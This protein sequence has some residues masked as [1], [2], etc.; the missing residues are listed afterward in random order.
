MKIIGLTKEQAKKNQLRYGFNELLKTRKNSPIKIFFSQFADFL[1]ITLICAML[2]SAFMGEYSDAITVLII[3]ATNGVLGFVQE[4]KTEKSLEALSKLSAPV[5]VVVRDGEEITIPSREVTV[6]DVVVLEAGD[7][8]C[9]DCTVIESTS[10]GVDESMLTGESV[11]IEKDAIKNTAIYMG[12]TVISGRCKARAEAIGMSTKMGSIAHLLENT[13]SGETPLKKHL[14]K[15]GRELV[16]ICL[17][18]CAL[19]FVAG[20]FHG[21]SVYNMFLSS[22]SLA[23]AAIPEG[24]PAVVTVSLS[25]GVSRMLKRNALIRKLPAVE[26]LGCTNVICSD[27][28][29]TLTQNKMT[30]KKIWCDGREV[31]AND[32]GT[33]TCLGKRVDVSSLPFS[34]LLTCAFECNNAM[35]RDG[36]LS[37]DP[38]EVAIYSLSEKSGATQKYGG[39]YE[40]VSEIPFDSNR[41]CMSVICKDKNGNKISFVKGA[42]DKIIDLCTKKQTASG[43]SSFD[44]KYA[45]KKAVDKMS[46]NALRVLAFAYKV[47]DGKDDDAENNLIFIGLEGMIDPPRKE[48]YNA[49][50]TC[51]EAKIKP[52][53]ITGDHKNTAKAIADELGFIGDNEPVTGEEL[54]KMSDD[55]LSEVVKSKNIF[56][57]VSPGD[58]LRIVKAFKRRRNIV[59]MTGDGVNDAPSLKEADIGISMGRCGTDVA[60]QAS[61]M[62]LLDDNFSTIIS[63]V[64]EGRMI[65]ENIRKFIRYL[66]SCNLGEIILMGASAF[67]GLPMPLV[68]IQILWMNLVTDGLP[69]LALGVDKPQSNLMKNPPRKEDESIFSKGLGG[70]VVLSGILIG[71]EALLAF[72]VSRSMFKDLQIAQTVSFCT[73]IF[74]ELLYAFECKSEK[75]SILNVKFFDNLY[76]LGAVILSFALTLAVIYIPPLASIFKTVPLTFSQWILVAVFGLTEAI[77]N[78]IFVKKN[79]E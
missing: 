48:A 6:G 8:V 32:D 44:N 43:V 77:L 16:L 7:R 60:K 13:V 26:T 57:R 67:C 37:G 65:Y 41:K 47:I 20:L 5:S 51:Y 75:G 53:M 73:L 54:E 10:L 61:D 56:A 50:K 15:I 39:M 49:I 25:I 23:V 78:I 46:H 18:V 19:I 76:L 14:N 22:I 33:L 31:D 74:A 64:E 66:L 35:Y 52:V 42:A 28:T 29:G 63:A 3:I 27:K 72:S 12:T 2:L 34:F 69:A 38:T 70:R 1:T 17:G 58:K 21:E 36:V 71:A 68:P 11:A 79:I 9:A 30:V 40:R 4:Y 24:L 62:I 59:A 45:V 55:E